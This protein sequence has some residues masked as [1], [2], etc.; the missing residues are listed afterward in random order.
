MTGS[1]EE[2][3]TRSVALSLFVSSGQRLAFDRQRKVKLRWRRERADLRSHPDVVRA[4]VRGARGIKRCTEHERNILAGLLEIEAHAG[5]RLAGCGD[6]FQILARMQRVRLPRRV[7]DI[8]AAGHRHIDPVA[9]VLRKISRLRDRIPR[10]QGAEHPDTLAS[11]MGLAL[12][13]QIVHFWLASGVSA[14][15]LRACEN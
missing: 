14:T 8:V 10:V 3:A 12:A 11:R 13:L 7:R 6:G 9:V 4:E 15:S 5:G 2:C 1:V